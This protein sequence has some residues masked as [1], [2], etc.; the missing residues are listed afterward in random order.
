MM[1]KRMINNRMVVVGA[2]VVLIIIG[3]AVFAPYLTPYDYKTNHLTERMLSP[4]L[5]H[6]MGT[7]NYGKDVWTR[8]IYG[9]RV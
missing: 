5:K 4:S 1:L 6:I 7:D 9:A 3:L 8:L 2:I